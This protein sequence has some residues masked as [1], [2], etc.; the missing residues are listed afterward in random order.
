MD[1]LLNG[2]FKNIK[3][4][5][6]YRFLNTAEIAPFVSGSNLTF[7]VPTDAAFER[8]GFDIL[9]DDILGSEMGVKM[10]LNHFVKGR[11]YDR[12]LKNDMLF[13]TV[14]GETLR[15]R[16]MGSNVTV[17]QANIIESEVFVYNLGTM[18]YLDDVLYSN[19]LLGNPPV[20]TTTTS[21]AVTNNPGQQKTTAQ[22]IAGST[23]ADAE[24]VPNEITVP[25]GTEE[26]FLM[27]DDEIIT[28]RA[29][30][31]IVNVVKRAN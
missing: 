14:G 9:P 25:N 7:F 19:Y 6:L 31:V 1:Y 23:A 20:T 16:R 15:I 28:P 21:A 27:D 12:D 3:F 29:L 30:P 5:S 13:E 4:I 2:R 17:N 11:L 22:V 18:F 24:L 10:L 26:D 8:L